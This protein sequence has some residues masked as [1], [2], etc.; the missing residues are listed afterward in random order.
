MVIF[1]FYNLYIWKNGRKPS[2]LKLN[3]D[4]NERRFW[5]FQFHSKMSISESESW[6]YWIIILLLLTI[7]CALIIEVIYFMRIFVCVVLARFVKRK[8][9]I[10]EKCSIGG[11]YKLKNPIMKVRRCTKKREVFVMQYLSTIITIRLFK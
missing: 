7:G 4:L 11:E 3:V 8:I 10:L 6:P 9:H 1:E 5:L 2:S